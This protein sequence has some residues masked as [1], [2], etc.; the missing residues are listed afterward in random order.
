MERDDARLR[1]PAEQLERHRQGVQCI[2]CDKRPEQ[3]KLD[4]FLWSRGA[5][6]QL[7]ER[8]YGI[9]LRV[10]SVGKYLARLW[11]HTAKAVQ[12]C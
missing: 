5:V 1:S 7:I 11:L 3:L 10:R 8:E 2:I 12:A 4:F 9:K 6:L